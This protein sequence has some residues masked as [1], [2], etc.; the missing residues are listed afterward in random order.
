MLTNL[1]SNSSFSA[2]DWQSLLSKLCT[3]ISFKLSSDISLVKDKALQLE[4]PDSFSGVEVLL[5]ANGLK[6]FLNSLPS[7]KDFRLYCK[8]LESTSKSSSTFSDDSQKEKFLK[9]EAFNSNFEE[10]WKQEIADSSVEVIREG[11]KIDLKSWIRNDLSSTAQEADLLKKIKVIVDA[12]EPEVFPID[13]KL[14]A[15]WDGSPCWI[16]PC[17]DQILF[18][19][20]YFKGKICG[21]ISA[22]QLVEI[23]KEKIISSGHG[24]VLPEAR[25]LSGGDIRS[26]NDSLIH[27]EKREV[28]KKLEKLTIEA[29]KLEEIS[30]TMSRTIFEGL[31]LSKITEKYIKDGISKA[32]LEVAA[33]AVSGMLEIAATSQGKG[34]DYMQQ[35]LKDKCKLSAEAAYAVA[36]GFIN[37]AKEAKPNKKKVNWL[38]LGILIFAIGTIIWFFFFK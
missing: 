22:E 19:Q 33:L 20:N 6:V 13:E 9:S 26:L 29:G 36:S 3:D 24:F 34:L 31:S 14:S 16:P 4:C 32:Q 12:K 30:Y 35:R 10:I 27:Y 21:E 25:K 18:S 7:R 1:I 5:Q 2:S 11:R 37:A 23:L 28:K 17:V 38:K 15:I 8:I